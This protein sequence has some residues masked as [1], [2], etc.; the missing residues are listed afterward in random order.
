MTMHRRHLAPL[1]LL[2]AAALL[3]PGCGSRAHLIPQADAATLSSNLRQIDSLLLKRRCDELPAAIATARQTAGSLPSSV[4]TALRNRIVA[5]LDRLAKQAPADCAGATTTKTTETQTNTVTTETQTTVTDTT[6]VTTP[7]ET[8]PAPTP[9]QTTPAPTPTQT[10]PA[11]TPTPTTPGGG[12]GGGGTSGG[13][14][15]GTGG[16]GGGTGG[17]GGGASPEGATP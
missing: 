2:A 6:P 1:L 8:T 12:G 9:T 15:G 4:D 5:G 11:P 3:L 17:S 7:T 14:T 10:T 16:S 13:G